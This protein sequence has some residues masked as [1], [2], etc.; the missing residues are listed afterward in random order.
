MRQRRRV[1]LSVI[2]LNTKKMKLFSWNSCFT[3]NIV[4]HHCAASVCTSQ[5]SR[6]CLLFWSNFNR[7][8]RQKKKKYF[9]W[10][11]LF[12]VN[13]RLCGVGHIANFHLKSNNQIL[14]CAVVVCVRNSLPLISGLSIFFCD[15]V[16]DNGTSHHITMSTFWE[17]KIICI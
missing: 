6:N 1:I 17:K 9:R 5:F 3:I 4:I 13:L 14:H 15:H 12:F 2:W 7:Y 11:M 16:E 8:L 10:E